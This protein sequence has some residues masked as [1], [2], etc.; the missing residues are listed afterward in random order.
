MGP[1][2]QDPEG[3]RPQQVVQAEVRLLQRLR[4]QSSELGAQRMARV[5]EGRRREGRSGEQHGVRVQG[6]GL[7]WVVGVLV[8]KHVCS[9]AAFLSRAMAC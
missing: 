6:L 1:L 7:C 9:A 3:V 8:S 2:L 4:Q 5:N